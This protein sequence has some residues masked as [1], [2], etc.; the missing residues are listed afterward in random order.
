[1]DL[2]LVKEVGLLLAMGAFLLVS[3]WAYSP[4]NKQRFEEDGM[5]PFIDEKQKQRKSS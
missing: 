1:M 4:R 5:L 3:W 2:V